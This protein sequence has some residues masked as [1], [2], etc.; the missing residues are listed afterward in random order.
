MPG[1]TEALYVLFI[2]EFMLCVYL[3]YFKCKY[4]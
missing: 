1:L 3:S 2:V 4:V